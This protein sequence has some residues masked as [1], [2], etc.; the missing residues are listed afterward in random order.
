MQQLTCIVINYVVQVFRLVVQLCSGIT[1]GKVL[2]GELYVHRF[3]SI[4]FQL[5]FIGCLFA[6]LFHYVTHYS[7][8]MYAEYFLHSYCYDFNSR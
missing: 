6:E 7:S 4:I 1:H 2:I 8:T 3:H 5:L